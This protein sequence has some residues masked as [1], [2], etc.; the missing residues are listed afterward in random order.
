ML[1]S[2]TQKSLLSIFILSFLILAQVNSY[3]QKDTTALWN[4]ETNDG[5][6]YS[7][8]IVLQT[9]TELKLRTTSI[10]TITLQLSNIKRMTKFIGITTAIS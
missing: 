6:E 3:A 4:I 10:G 7:G 5:N 8:V 2:I 9:E 1:K